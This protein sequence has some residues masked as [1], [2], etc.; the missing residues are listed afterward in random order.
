MPVAYIDLPSGLDVDTKKKL[1]KKVAESIHHAYTTHLR[2]R[3]PARAPCRGETAAR[4][5]G[6]LGDRRGM[7]LAARGGP[8]PE[9]QYGRHEMGNL[10]LQRGPA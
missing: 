5:A 7:Q 3:R 8:A 2:F 6:Q 10:F 9:W 1:V 4:Q